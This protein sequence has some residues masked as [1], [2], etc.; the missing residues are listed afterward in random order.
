MGSRLLEAAVAL[1]RFAGKILHHH[2]GLSGS[3]EASWMRM[4]L[5]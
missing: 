1:E 5:G 3:I 4:M 2:I